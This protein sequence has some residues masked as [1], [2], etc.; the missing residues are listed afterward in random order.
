MMGYANNSSGF[1]CNV[2]LTGRRGRLTI[3][4]KGKKKEENN[5]V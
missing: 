4:W 2:C 1:Y 3:R 5:R